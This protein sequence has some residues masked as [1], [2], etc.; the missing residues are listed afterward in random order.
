MT[1]LK[2]KIKV[3]FLKKFF[4]TLLSGYILKLHQ[5][6]IKKLNYKKK[7]F[8]PNLWVLLKMFKTKLRHKNKINIR[9]YYI[10]VEFSREKF[11]ITFEL[12]KPLR[13]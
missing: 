10:W 4:Y 12:I 8:L 6:F 2:T 5:N 11:K 13:I 3:Y 9:K 1:V 7:Y